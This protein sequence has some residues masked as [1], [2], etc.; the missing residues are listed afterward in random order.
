MK[1]IVR[2]LENQRGFHDVALVKRALDAL[3]LEVDPQKVIVV[4]GTNGKGSTCATLQTL[5]MAAG[6]NVGLYS[7]P[8]LIKINE[9]IKFNGEDISD[10][11]FF[12][13][14]QQVHEKI[15]PNDLSCFEYL[16]L[17][18]AYYFFA[19]KKVDFAI[20]EVGLGGICDATRSI[21]HD[22]SVI[23]KLGLDH[24]AILGN[25][26]VEIAKNKFGVIGESNKVFHTKFDDAGVVELSQ[27]IA[28]KH[29]AELIEAYPHDCVV[30]NIGEYPD[31]WIKTQWGNFKMNL[32]GKRAAENTALATTIFDHLV[33]D[34]QKFL[35]AIGQV[36]WPGRMEKIRRQN[37]DVFLSGDHNPQG[38]DSL[39]DIL[40][41]YN[42]DKVHLVVG[43]C[44][45][46]KHSQ[47]LEKLINFPNFIIYLTETP[48]KTLSIQDYDQKFLQ[49]AA[50]ISSDPME[51]LDVA[52]SRS[53]KDDLV[54][55]TGSLY[56]IGK[57]KNAN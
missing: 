19:V 54:L 48:E 15:R 6:K 40:R 57:I 52:I 42:F 32:Q 33:E 44:H 23:T 3:K 8:H 26:L 47:M 30:V 7:S 28:A 36:N 45:D 4:A 12:E 50:F 17:M 1:N 2:F 21:P 27:K 51:V 14:F 35:P 34:A 25:S 5:L 29:H 39:L 37:R 16:T 10:D 24:E 13:I 49:R 43:I 46:K 9:R 56:L 22:V 11:D 38:I 55:A 31:F 20:F 53:H 41:H 18:A